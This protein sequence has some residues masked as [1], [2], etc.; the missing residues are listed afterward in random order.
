[1]AAN[2]QTDGP[3]RIRRVEHEDFDEGRGYSV[4]AG[5]GE[6]IAVFAFRSHA[7]RFVRFVAAVRITAGAPEIADDKWYDYVGGRMV[8]MRGHDPAKFYDEPPEGPP[9]VSQSQTP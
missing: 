7:V 3:F 6:S 4:D 9:D 5:N 8:Q 1:M 2:K